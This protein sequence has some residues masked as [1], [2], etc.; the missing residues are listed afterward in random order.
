VSHGSQRKEKRRET[1]RRFESLP[2]CFLE[3]TEGLVSAKDYVAFAVSIVLDDR[4]LIRR[5]RPE[6]TSKV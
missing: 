6:T 4:K 1:R 3:T 2:A 5:R